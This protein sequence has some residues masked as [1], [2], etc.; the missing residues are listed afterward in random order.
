MRLV[1][2]DDSRKV[3]LIDETGTE[4]GIFTMRE[5]LELARE[6]GRDL[7]IVQ[8][9]AVP[10]VA[11]MMNYGRFKFDQQKKEREIKRKHHLVDI[12]EIKMRYKIEAH[13]Y[14]IKL[15]NAQKF[16]IEGDKIKVVIMLRGREVQHAQIAFNLM[17][18]FSDDL[19]DLAIIDREP[20]LEGKSVI[21]LLSAIPRRG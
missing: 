19:K 16:L 3:R 20:Y 5:A 10:P 18:R 15:Q 6:K 8:P 21:M 17:K 13:D 9:D 1:P 7:Y 14:A 12:K 4:L 11:R 2:D